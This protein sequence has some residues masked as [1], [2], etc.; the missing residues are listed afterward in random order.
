MPA[1][2]V[3]HTARRHVPVLSAW[4]RHAAVQHF[5]KCPFHPFAPLHR[6]RRRDGPAECDFPQ[7]EGRASG[8]QT[9]RA[10]GRR[11]V[12]CCMRKP[13]TGPQSKTRYAVSRPYRIHST[14]RLIGPLHGWGYHL[15]VFV[16]QQPHWLPGFTCN[17]RNPHLSSVAHFRRHPRLTSFFILAL[18]SQ[19][20]EPFLPLQHNRYVD[21]SCR[22]SA[23]SLYDQRHTWFGTASIVHAVSLG[24]RYS[25]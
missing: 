25:P 2:P 13:P 10:Y 7:T 3:H 19:S 23:S 5:L 17:Q 8:R 24:V 9:G 1:Q 14:A 22:L 18:T 6:T 21:R 4:L 16:L 12:G 11:C 15:D 20:V